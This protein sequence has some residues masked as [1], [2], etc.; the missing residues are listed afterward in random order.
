M[1]QLKETKQGNLA[2]I[3]YYAGCMANDKV[4]DMIQNIFAR[5]K[6]IV[7]PVLWSEI[8]KMNL[9]IVAAS[10]GLDHASIWIKS[11]ATNE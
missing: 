10:T 6:M 9:A 2:E 3:Y 11:Q 7:K 5:I 1:G 8:C 4:N